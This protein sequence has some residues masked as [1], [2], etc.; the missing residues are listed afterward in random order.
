MPP[1]RKSAESQALCG[2]S[3]WGHLENG[4]RA[5]AGTRPVSEYRPRRS[6]GTAGGSARAAGSAGAPGR[7]GAQPPCA[8]VQS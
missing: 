3:F 4:D 5:R 6:A 2:P 8:G 1:F 7:I